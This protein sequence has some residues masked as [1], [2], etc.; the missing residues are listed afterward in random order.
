M[1]VSVGP[2]HK[3]RLLLQSRLSQRRF[4]TRPGDLLAGCINSMVAG[5]RSFEGERE[6]DIVFIG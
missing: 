1:V 2:R 6:T 5:E 4:R 3:S